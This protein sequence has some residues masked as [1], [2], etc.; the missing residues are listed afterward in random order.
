MEKF[1]EPPADLLKYA[2]GLIQYEYSNPGYIA[3]QPKHH[4]E[5]FLNEFH[6]LIETQDVDRQ[7]TLHDFLVS[8]EKYGGM[9]ELL[10]AL[11]K[12]SPEYEK[13]AESLYIRA[14]KD[15]LCFKEEDQYTSYGNPDL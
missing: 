9:F 5:D 2:Y 15:I 7:G 6:A 11:R 10:C 13:Y 3:S 1:C 12:T 14:M 4:I 8:I